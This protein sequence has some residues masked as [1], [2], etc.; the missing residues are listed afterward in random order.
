MGFSYDNLSGEEKKDEFSH[1]AFD[2]VRPFGSKK[3]GDPERMM[4]DNNA[5]T[6]VSDGEVFGNALNNVPLVVQLE[7]KRRNRKIDL[8]K[9]HKKNILSRLNENRLE[10]PRTS[11]EE[12]LRELNE[13]FEREYYQHEWYFVDLIE[14]GKVPQGMSPEQYYD[15]IYN[16][17]LEKLEESRRKLRSSESFLSAP[18]TIKRFR[19]EAKWSQEMA[20]DLKAYH[21]ISDLSEEMSNGLRTFREIPKLEGR[22]VKE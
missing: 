6:T 22:K 9:M 21:G 4:N 5:S 3:S 17:G 16:K 7:R 15:L 14:S 19:A 18:K 10:D 13:A 1:D 12:M 20:D 2:G 11:Q 8:S